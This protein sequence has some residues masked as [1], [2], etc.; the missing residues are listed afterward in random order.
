[1]ASPYSEELAEKNLIL[2]QKNH[3]LVGLPS[4]IQSYNYLPESS[5]RRKSKFLLAIETARAFALV[6]ETEGPAPAHVSHEDLMY[7][8]S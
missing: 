5:T 1:M 2:P 4:P 3:K 7:C 6:G 8:N